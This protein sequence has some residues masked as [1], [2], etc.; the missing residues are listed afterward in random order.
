MRQEL[1]A[2]AVAK[3]KLQV[4]AAM[5]AIARELMDIKNGLIKLKK[6]CKKLTGK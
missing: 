5:P 4:N 2:E 1:R 3:Q 6:D